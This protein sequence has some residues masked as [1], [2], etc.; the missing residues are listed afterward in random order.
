VDPRGTAYWDVV[1]APYNPSEFKM[2]ANR[3]LYKLIRNKYDTTTQ[4]TP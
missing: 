1:Y 4:K 2:I 3:S